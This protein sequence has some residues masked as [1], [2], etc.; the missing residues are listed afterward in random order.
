M[1]SNVLGPFSNPDRIQVYRGGIAFRTRVDCLL[2]YLFCRAESLLTATIG[3]D[4]PILCLLARVATNDLSSISGLHR[5]DRAQ[6][7][8]LNTPA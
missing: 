3:D 4:S 8:A 6:P 2:L 5:R 1:P 7:S